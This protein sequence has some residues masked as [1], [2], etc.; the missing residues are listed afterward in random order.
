MSHV[1]VNSRKA[2]LGYAMIEPVS[3]HMSQCRRIS[4][5]MANT[6]ST[7]RITSSTSRCFTAKL[8]CH[9]EDGSPVVS[10]SYTSSDAVRMLD[11][12]TTAPPAWKL[13]L[14]RMSENSFC[15]PLYL[16]VRPT[17]APA[18]ASALRLHRAPTSACS[19]GGART[20]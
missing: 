19:E 15:G 18:A 2:Y 13:K 7:S 12:A 3:V 9:S 14:T 20:R 8:P 16:R 4:Y 1:V 5:G 6:A 11:D 17:T 10:E